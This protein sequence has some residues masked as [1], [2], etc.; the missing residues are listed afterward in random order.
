MSCVCLGSLFGFFCVFITKKKYQTKR[1]GAFLLPFGSEENLLGS[2]KKDGLV[3]KGSFCR[4]F[5]GCVGVLFVCWAESRG[6]TKKGVG[7]ERKS[8]E[9]KGN[10]FVD[11]E[12]HK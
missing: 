2:R 9:T 6:E 8:E 11:F 3:E 10:S 12:S 5:G 1:W 4:F 7:V